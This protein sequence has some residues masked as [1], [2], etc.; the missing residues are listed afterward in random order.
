MNLQASL[1]CEQLFTDL[2]FEFSDTAVC[3]YVRCQCALDCKWPE[4]LR[5]F[6]RLFMRVYADVSNNVARLF[7]LF[8]AVN[9]LMPFDAIHLQC[10]TCVIGSLLCFKFKVGL[11]TF[12]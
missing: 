8:R 3:F 10:N 1:S 11:K 6:V 7:E 4:T 2:A 9:T 5:A 12:E